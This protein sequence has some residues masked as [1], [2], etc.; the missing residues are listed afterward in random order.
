MAYQF[1]SAGQQYLSAGSCPVSGTPITI[2]VWFY[3][4]STTNNGRLISLN[5][6]ASV[7]RLTI[8]PTSAQIV[9]VTSFTSGGSTAAN[10]AT[11]NLNAWNHVAGVYSSP[12]S[13]SA[14]MNGSGP[15]TNTSTSFAVS[16]N[17]LNIG[18]GI[19]SGS[20]AGF[21]DAIIA[22][23]GIWNAALTTGEI[24]ALSKGIS[25]GQVRPQSIV[26]HAPLIR[27]LVDVRGG[28]SLTNNNGATVADHPRLY[29]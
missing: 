22:D 5:V 1:T 28:L 16:P 10:S 17:L 25:C 15:V 24:I 18:A 29:L 2:S 13:R 23:V 14:Y 6:S 11:Y 12:T 26:F 4:Q 8:T 9:Q 3:K 21:G 27:D 19:I 20:P 7:D